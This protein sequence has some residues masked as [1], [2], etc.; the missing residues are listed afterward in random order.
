MKEAAM[1][2]FAMILSDNPKVWSGGSPAEMQA[3]LQ[4]YSD[5]SRKLGQEGKLK[6]GEKLSFEPGKRLRKDG[7][8]VA[9]DGPFAETKEMVSGLFFIEAPDYPAA[10]EIAKTCPHLDYGSIVVHQI[11]EMKD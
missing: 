2:R 9:V 10:V 8:R 5:W 1:P 3:V 6:G 11:D 4:R 7:A